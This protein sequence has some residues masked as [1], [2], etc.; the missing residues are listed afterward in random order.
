MV[1]LVI[2]SH[3]L[4]KLGKLYPKINGILLK[5]LKLLPLILK[6]LSGSRAQRDL[7]EFTY[8][9]VLMRT[10]TKKRHEKLC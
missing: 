4:Q 6:G 1:L 5:S 9:N 10:G 3:Q 8:V 7:L 2:L